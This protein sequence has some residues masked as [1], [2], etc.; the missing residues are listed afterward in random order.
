MPKRSENTKY[1]TQVTPDPALEKRSRRNFP[2]E[3]KT[4]IVALAD[5]CQRG[6]LGELL[7]KEK[8]Y[9]GQIIQWRKELRDGDV[10]KLAKSAP[11]PK[12]KLSNEHK[13]IRRLEN[14]NQDTNFKNL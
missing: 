10:E 12:A 14:T 2:L 1:T 5:N 9:S 8:L 13:E 6:E 3:Y 7:R 11:S 4:R